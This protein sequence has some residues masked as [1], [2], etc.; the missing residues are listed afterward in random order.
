MPLSEKEQRILQQIEQ[1]LESDERF[2]NSVKPSGIYAH[3]VRKVWWAG[4][5]AIASLI[6]TVATLQV[7]FLLAFAGFLAM[8]GCVL[9]IEKQLRAMSKVGLKDVA[10]SLRKARTNAAS[11]RIKFGKDI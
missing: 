4:L 5:G 10:A 6:F 9:I 3:S 2:A 8:L 7:H 1:S 11:S